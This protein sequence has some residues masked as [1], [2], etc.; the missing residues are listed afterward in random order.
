MDA[1]GK[2]AAFSAAGRRRMLL[3]RGRLLEG[4]T[5]AWNVVGIV[6]LAIVFY[7]L[8]EAREI[9][10]PGLLALCDVAKAPEAP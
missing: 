8:R 10:M 2:S 1:N 4:I 9:F 7:A 5:L 6:V 3:R